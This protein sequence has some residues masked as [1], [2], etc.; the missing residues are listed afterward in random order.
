M[1]AAFGDFSRSPSQTSMENIFQT[2]GCCYIA[3]NEQAMQS[4]KNGGNLHSDMPLR[5]V[6]KER[7]F[8]KCQRE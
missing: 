7:K 1:E 5:L 3:F 8:P 4:N 2:E 6:Q